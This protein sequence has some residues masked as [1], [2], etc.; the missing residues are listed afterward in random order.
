M[1]KLKILATKMPHDSFIITV[2]KRLPAELLIDANKNPKQRIAVAVKKAHC[3]RGRDPAN[4]IAKEEPPKN[5]PKGWYEV[6]SEQVQMAN[7]GE[8]FPPLTCFIYR[9]TWGNIVI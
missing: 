2:S 7:M 3:V 6:C 4:V 1:Q 5:D 9:K 8:N